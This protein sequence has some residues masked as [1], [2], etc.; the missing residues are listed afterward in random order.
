[1]ADD[2]ATNHERTRPE[3]L[4]SRPPVPAPA[5]LVV[6][7]GPD[8]GR[9]IQLSARRVVVGRSSASDLRLDDDAVSRAHA[10]LRDD[11]GRWFVRD[12][13]STNG[14]HLNDV[15]LAGESPLAHGDRL[16]IGATTF[17][18]LA[19]ADE[20]RAYHEELYRRRTRDALTGAHNR[21]YFQEQ[22]AR[23]WTAARRGGPLALLLLDV[24]HFKQVNDTH[25]HAAGDAVLRALPA[26]V[27][28]LLRPGDTFARY[29]GEEFALLLPDCEATRA[30][31]VA[32]GIRRAVAGEPVRVGASSIPVTVSVG[33]AVKDPTFATAEELVARADG[34]LYAAKRGG[35]NRVHG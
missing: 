27:E 12:L 13:G 33:V 10:E 30:R 24:D 21:G 8:L 5:G 14:T 15:R 16:R 26:R 9:Q 20:E 1:M 23:E 17:R 22:L 34:H 31:G 18:F 35:R 25:G 11:A 7:A 19:A 6:L 28:P 4:P 2:H 32:E 29:G 3:N